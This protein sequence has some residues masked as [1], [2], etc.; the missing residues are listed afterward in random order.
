MANP[1]TLRFV[2]ECH[3]DTTLVR[4]L[5]N[6]YPGID[7]ES[8]I[9]NVANNLKT[10]TIENVVLVGI[11]DDDPLP[12]QPTYL[13]DFDLLEKENRVLL[14]KKPGKD[15]YVVSVQPAIEKFLIENCKSVGEKLSNYG[16]PD[17]LKQFTKHTK[18]PEIEQ[19]QR[20]IDLLKELK[21]KNAP[22]ILTLEKMLTQFLQQ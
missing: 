20:F 22:G 9:G 8:S 21:N 17:D 16:F 3:A 18:K 12:R 6:G 15:H 7:H 10:V 4:F 5:T 11:V 1:S 14:K 2:P 13:K 19:N